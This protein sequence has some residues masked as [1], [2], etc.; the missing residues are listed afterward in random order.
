MASYA[1]IAEFDPEQ[2]AIYRRSVERRGI[3]AIVVREGSAAVRVLQTRGAPLLLISDLTLPQA[4]GFSLIAELRRR[5]PPERTAVLVFS[6]HPELRAAAWNL[7]GTLGI[8]EV[9]DKH[10]V[11]DAIAQI[12]D[13]TLG[14]MTRTQHRGE[15]SPRF[16]ELLQKIAFRTSKAFRSPIVILSIELRT[17]RH[18]TGYMSIDE[19]SGGPELWAVLQQVQRTREPLVVPDLT[20]YSLFGL[21]P[22]QPAIE[23]RSFATV[24]LIT[25]AGRTV[26]AISLVD[27][28]PHTLTAP[29]LDLL[30]EAARTIADELARRYQNDL[31]QSEIVDAPP[32]KEQWAALERLALTDWL[33]GLSN[34]HAGEQALER[35]LARVRR[36]GAPFSL[37]LIDLDRFKQ[38]N[39]LHG[40][41]TGDEV[42]RQI[43][44]ILT[45]TFRASDLAVRWGGDEFL[46]LLPD[47]PLSGA[48]MFAERA[49]TQVEK[50]AFGGA[51]QMTMSVGI[52]Q[53]QENEDAPSAVRRADAHLY[54]AKRAGRNRVSSSSTNGV[55][56]RLTPER[57]PEHG[58]H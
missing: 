42:L 35:E 12:I 36:T 38:V 45:S 9:A 16:D 33:T 24:P 14:K 22:Q 10:L 1:L 2:T 51:G 48:V 40:H 28:Q 54:E 27:L 55:P 11:P 34:R 52:V 5:Y 56:K 57:L 37:A 46:V 23:V 3:E 32:S 26:G 31:A 21:G 20:N 47:V 49:R 50:L 29:Q 44:K 30:L 17:H 25:S 43:G 8:A 19:L 15:A 18:I 6:A 4:D 58:N 41:A 7:R 39:D 13:R 53:F